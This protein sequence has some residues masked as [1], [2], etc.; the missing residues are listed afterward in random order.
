MTESSQ[1]GHESLTEAI[2]AVQADMP[3][4][5]KG[6]INPHFQS[7]YV[8]LDTLMAEV[9]PVL[10]RHGLI[11]LTMPCRDTTGEPALG[12]KLQ[13]VSTREEVGAVM[14]LLMARDDP[15][16]QGSAITYARRYALM[17]LLGLVADVDDDGNAATEARRRQRQARDTPTHLTDEQIETMKTRI[18]EAGFVVSEVVQQLGIVDLRHATVGEG[19]R[20]R[21]FLIKEV[22]GDVL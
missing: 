13:L 18:Q 7:R 3:K 8:S 20:V 22:S 1:Q 10:N 11:W 14:P 6:A 17:A 5:Q 12:Y 9:L 16:G 15:Q 19:R 2:H 4:L 21:D